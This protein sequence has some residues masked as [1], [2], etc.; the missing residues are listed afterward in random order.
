MVMPMNII[1]AENCIKK[2]TLNDQKEFANKIVPNNRHMYVIY[3][4]IGLY[5]FLL[6]NTGIN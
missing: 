5:I 2:P 1:L 3:E 4:A 6:V